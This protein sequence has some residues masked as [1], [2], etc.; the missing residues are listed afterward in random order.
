MYMDKAQFNHFFVVVVCLYKN[1]VLSL[2]NNTQIQE[3]KIKPP[4]K[5]PHNKHK[6]PK[7]FMLTNVWV[8][9]LHYFAFVL[10]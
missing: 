1:R 10:W 7:L 6:L 9:V 8:V 4:P 3:K 2:N 5:P